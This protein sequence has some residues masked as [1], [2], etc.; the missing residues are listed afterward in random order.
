ML[1]DKMTFQKKKNPVLII[2]FSFLVDAQQILYC[3]I[4]IEPDP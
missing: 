4:L 3:H 2:D 1:G